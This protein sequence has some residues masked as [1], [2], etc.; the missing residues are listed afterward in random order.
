MLLGELAERLSEAEALSVA[1]PADIDEGLLRRL[2][3]L[4]Y[5]R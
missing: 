3:A 2:R 5:I 1:T 4:G